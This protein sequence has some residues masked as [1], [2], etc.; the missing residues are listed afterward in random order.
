[1]NEGGVTGYGN[2]MRV[3]YTAKRACRLRK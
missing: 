1:M 2:R 3:K